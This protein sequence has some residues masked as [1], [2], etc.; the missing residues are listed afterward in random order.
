MFEI[1]FSSPKF[2]LQEDKF[3]KI[4]LLSD[5]ISPEFGFKKPNKILINVDFPHPLAPNII[6][7]VPLSKFK[8]KFFNTNL[9]LSYENDKFLI[10]I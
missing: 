10:E 2:D 1:N 3:K 8:F 4:L 9:E 7:V 6:F 5:K